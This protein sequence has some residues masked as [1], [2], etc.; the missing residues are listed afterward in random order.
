M[1]GRGDTPM[2]TMV[3]FVTLVQR[4]RLF[5]STTLAR[6]R[7]FINWFRHLNILL[8]NNMYKTLIVNKFWC[9]YCDA[10]DKKR[11]N[12]ALT[13]WAPLSSVAKFERG[14]RTLILFDHVIRFKECIIRPT[15]ISRS[16]FK[17]TLCTIYILLV[18]IMYLYI[19]IYNIF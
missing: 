2:H 11:Y 5:C 1:G 6:G 3:T 16:K 15:E 12:F 7:R 8:F 18:M 17:S 13:A 9:N 4:F 14:W 10:A 19:G